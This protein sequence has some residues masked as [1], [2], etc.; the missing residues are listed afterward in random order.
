[1]QPDRP[2]LKRA[3]EDDAAWLQRL[4]KHDMVVVQ[5]AD[6]N[7]ENDQATKHKLSTLA[8][9][10]V[11]SAANPS[12]GR[13]EALRWL[14]HDP[15]GR[16]LAAKHF[17][18][19]ETTMQSREEL[20]IS[21]AKEYGPVAVAK[22]V[23]DT[24]PGTRITEW[25]LTKALTEACQPA[26]GQSKA[27]AFAKLLE[28]DQT[29]REAYAVIA[30]SPAR[31]HSYL[32]NEPLTKVG[33]ATGPMAVTAP[34]FVGGEEGSRA[35]TSTDDPPTGDI[36]RVGNDAYS[37][38]V[39]LCNAQL[40]ARGLSSAYFARVFSEVYQD[41]ANAALAELERRQNRPG[42]VERVAT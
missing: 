41:P 7:F 12:F 30:S 16:L 22:H 6:G 31:A 8:D 18:K 21:V 24:G 19:E 35:R 29:V 37:Q 39:A 15:K 3:D 5:K 14:I 10:V 13:A 27:Q 33:P 26:Q 25:E 32:Q 17:D 36:G 4:R 42:G 23:I 34:V 38:L 11:E 28:S 2:Y 9:L 20:L 1:M 40:K